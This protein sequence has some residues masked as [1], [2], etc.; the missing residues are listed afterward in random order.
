MRARRGQAGQGPSK[1]LVISSP[2]IFSFSKNYAGTVGFLRDMKDA[3]LSR[4]RDRARLVRIDLLP[5]KSISVAAA[6]V[7]S[8]EVHRWREVRG[9][10]LVPQDLD[11]WNP[12]VRRVLSG[13]G[14][15][16]LLNLDRP[17]ED[18][19]IEDGLISIFPIHS[20]G[21]NVGHDIANALEELGII[22]R[23]FV[24]REHVY[25]AL[26]EAVTNTVAHAYRKKIAQHIGNRYPTSHSKWWFAS[27]YDDNRDEVRLFIYDQGVGIPATLPYSKV[28]PWVVRVLKR[29][30]TGAVYKDSELIRAAVETRETSTKETHHGRGLAVIIRVP[31]EAKGGQVRIFS[32]KGNLTYRFGEPISTSDERLHI[33][34]TLIEW[35]IPCA[36]LKEPN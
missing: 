9:A 21:K 12:D 17:E 14:M 6:V 32:G 3:T 24:R 23:L 34:G 36:P 25:E 29:L 33:G 13:L 16:D 31:D 4:G 20:G 30:F 19:T 26:L 15:F 2:E 8:A 18:Y 7:L 27:C 10:N 22:D 5:I 1:P 11:R 35:R 28:W